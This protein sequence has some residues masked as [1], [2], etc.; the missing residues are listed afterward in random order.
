ML[1]GFGAMDVAGSDDEEDSE[2]D[3][4]ADANGAAGLAGLITS[5]GL[6]D[7]MAFAGGNWAPLEGAQGRL[8]D[9]LM[10]GQDTPEER[11]ARADS[12]AQTVHGYL[13]SPEA[14]ESV[15][16]TMVAGA[17]L[18]SLSLPILRRHAAAMIDVIMAERPSTHSA[19]PTF[20]AAYGA[21]T[22]GSP[23]PFADAFIAVGKTMLG[24]WVHAASDCFSDGVT[25]VAALMQR[26]LDLNMAGMLPQV[27]VDRLVNSS[28]FEWRNTTVLR[29]IWVFLLKRPLQGFE[30]MGG[31][32]SGMVSKMV[33]KAYQGV[34]LD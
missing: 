8:R 33:M 18:D 11:V 29:R 25:S 31:M 32:V 21:P 7:L 16:G 17:D 6:P 23:T 20:V 22:E 4:M 9:W 12:L 30:F 10:P 1:G 15:R 24:E 3:H 5:F 13:S 28:V 27:C 14:L 26:A 34:C 2:D 19:Q